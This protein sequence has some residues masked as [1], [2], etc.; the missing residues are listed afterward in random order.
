MSRFSLFRRFVSV[1][2]GGSLLIVHL[3]ARVRAEPINAANV[4]EAIRL[5]AALDVPKPD[6]RGGWYVVETANFFVCSDESHEHA[7]EASRNAEALRNQLRGRWLGETDDMPWRPRCHLVLHR[8]RHSY[9]AAVGRGSDAT[10]GSSLITVDEDRI[11]GRRIDLLCGSHPPTNALPHELT[12]VVLREKFVTDGVPRWA[13]EGA[14]V[15][16]DP[17]AKRRRHLNDLEAASAGR[18]TFHVAELLTTIEYPQADRWGAYYG[19]S[20][21]LVGFLVRRK[22]HVRFVEFLEQASR[23]GYDEALEHCYGIADVRE[24][25]RLWRLHAAQEVADDR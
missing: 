9:S 21:S 23:N 3:A 20:A 7:V 25:D 18:S 8:T 2:L 24:L 11:T 6:R 22:S 17:L 15:L 12:H 4:S 14:A 5:G 10:V 1:A 19:Q 16:A 13:D